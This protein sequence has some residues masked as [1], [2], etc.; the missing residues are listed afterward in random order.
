[1]L[2]EV[3][4]GDSRRPAKP[5]DSHW[6]KMYVE[7]P[8][9]NVPK[10]HT[11]FHHRFHM[12]YSQFIQFVSEAKENNWFPCCCRWNSTTPIELLI[13]GGFRN[14][15]QGLTFDD[16]EECTI[17]SAEVHR[18]YFHEFVYN[19]ANILYPMYVVVPTT[20]EECRSHVHEFQLAGFNGAIGSTDAKCIAIEKC[21]YWLRIIWA[22][23]SNLQ[24]AP[25]TLQ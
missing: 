6:W 2:Y 25:S 14:L 9:I 15:G 18:N 12:P 22:Q 24:H 8:M 11:C 1:M 21:C 3:W 23:R 13:L 16:L 17:I 4:D 10:F 19:G 7:H 5:I 20:M